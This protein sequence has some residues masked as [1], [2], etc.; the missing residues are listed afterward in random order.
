M[1]I[2]ISE[3]TRRLVLARGGRPAVEPDKQ[4]WL[5]A[6]RTRRRRQ[7]AQ[8]RAALDAIPRWSSKNLERAHRLHESRPWL[9]K[10]PPPP[11]ISRGERARRDRREVLQCVLQ[12]AGGSAAESALL[13]CTARRP[14]TAGTQHSATSGAIAAPD[15]VPGPELDLRGAGLTELDEDVVHAVARR[16]GLQPWNPASLRRSLSGEGDRPWT[17]STTT[18]LAS[19]RV[20]DSLSL[21]VI[22]G[23]DISGV[24]RAW[25]TP[26][27]CRTCANE[28]VATARTCHFCGTVLEPVSVRVDGLCRPPGI[29]VPDVVRLGQ[30]Q[31]TEAALE[32]PVFR[33]TLEPFLFLNRLSSLRVLDLSSNRL[34]VL[35]ASLFEELPGL[36]S[37]F[38]QH[39]QFQTMSALEGLCSLLGLEKL[40]LHGCPLHERLKRRRFRLGVLSLV[41]SV[42]QLDLTTV[43]PLEMADARQA[44]QHALSTRRASIAGTLKRPVVRAREL[45]RVTTLLQRRVRQE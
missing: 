28:N 2:H 39:N 19:R 35:E 10:P 30:N 23:V 40:A 12:E 22:G 25:G 32:L 8:E 14:S 1:T 15:T 41:P 44:Q 43:S 37:L 27:Q 26:F 42:K 17:S 45:G 3:E 7:E 31:L 5:A 6:E 18:S 34:R 13:D 11:V 20:S 29:A 9:E 33:R 16:R 4:K 24:R 36:Q 38:A 21:D